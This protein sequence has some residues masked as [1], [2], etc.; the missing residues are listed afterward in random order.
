[1]QLDTEKLKHHMAIKF[2]NGTSLAAA[3]GITRQS[4][5]RILRGDNQPKPENFKLICEALDV[6]PRELLKEI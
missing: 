4:I 1:M 5:Y 6:D 2:M 3:T